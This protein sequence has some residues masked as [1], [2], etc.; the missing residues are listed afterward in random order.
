[1]STEGV[2]FQIFGGI[3]Y[4]ILYIKMSNYFYGTVP[5]SSIL[6][7]GSD[8]VTGF[9]NVSGN[10][11][12]TISFD[13][14]N[15]TASKPKPIPFP[16]QY[17][18][19]SLGNFAAKH[20]QYTTVGAGTANKPAGANAMRFII[21][22][23][24]GGGG[25][26]SGGGWQ[27]AGEDHITQGFEGRVGA[28]G[29]ITYGNEVSLTN[30]NSVSFNIGIGGGGGSGGLGTPISSANNNVQNSGVGADGSSGG[31]TNITIG[32]ATY[33]GNLGVGGVGGPSQRAES[34]RGWTSSMVGANTATANFRGNLAAV[35]GYGN[36]L[37]G[38]T[39]NYT[40]YGSYNAVPP[41][42]PVITHT[43]TAPTTANNSTLG[44]D[45][46]FDNSI[47]TFSRSG[48]AFG[49]GGWGYRNVNFGS[50]KTGSAGSGGT[51][52]QVTI[53]WLY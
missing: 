36:T 9:Y 35:A 6:Q 32:A 2:L 47:V 45:A 37:Y 24:G 16:Y 15:L 53:I 3:K 23:G 11:V 34:D 18:N 51:S 40:G 43:R 1:V 39:D 7:S 41:A 46:N 49:A 33:T 12:S 52:G 42:T 14:T 21:T 20:V 27:G 31:A 8:V 38:E 44:S 29:G 25:G 10:T 5:L 17:L 4:Y 13:S 48:G 22:G 26:G 28:D 50:A 19:T 30:I